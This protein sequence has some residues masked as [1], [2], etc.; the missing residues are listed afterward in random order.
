[1]CRGKRFELFFHNIALNFRNMPSC[2][3]VADTWDCPLHD[4]TAWEIAT[5]RRNEGSSR[6]IY[7][8]TKTALHETYA[9]VQ[10]CKDVLYIALWR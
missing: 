3:T 2:A 10:K 6:E 4:P 9:A 5:M 1:M 8:S 7:V